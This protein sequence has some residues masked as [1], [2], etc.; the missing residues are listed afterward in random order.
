MMTKNFKAAFVLTLFGACAVSAQS[1]SETIADATLQSDEHTTLSAA[2]QVA[3]LTDRLQSEG[4]FT[5]F[6]PDDAAFAALSTEK[7]GELFDLNNEAELEDL[8]EGHIVIGALT[9]QDI[10]EQASNSADGFTQ[11]ETV[12]GVGLMAEM[13]GQ[14]VYLYDDYGNVS[15]VKLADL[16]QSNG[17]IHVIDTVL[18]IN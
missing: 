7:V 11:L 13:R 12:S 3:G 6:A 1:L 4:P 18:S 14:D 16:E 5:V 2:V 9:A 8:L 17:V 15:R 10:A